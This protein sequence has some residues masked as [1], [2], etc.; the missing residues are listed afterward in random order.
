MKTIA[1]VSHTKIICCRLHSLTTICLSR[2]SSSRLRQSK[3]K[4]ANT[5]IIKKTTKVR[6]RG[7]LIHNSLFGYPN[8]DFIIWI[9]MLW[10][11]FFW[12]MQKLLTSAEQ[13]RGALSKRRL[14]NCRKGCIGI[15]MHYKL[16]DFLLLLPNKYQLL[17]MTYQRLSNSYMNI[18]K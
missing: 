5:S 6:Y 3:S 13:F 12:R 15:S 8:P 16:V 1:I 11:Q 14:K 7:I 17:G 2:L 10:T 9:K 4:F 18:F